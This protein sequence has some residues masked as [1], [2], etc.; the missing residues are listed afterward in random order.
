ML[1]RKSLKQWP[2]KRGRI[3]T[4]DQDEQI[5]IISDLLKLK[6]F[7]GIW[8]NDG[9]LSVRRFRDPCE[10]PQYLPWKRAVQMIDAARSL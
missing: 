4:P 1:R 10:I 7:D 3:F 5:K 6:H 9:V 2:V 8:Y